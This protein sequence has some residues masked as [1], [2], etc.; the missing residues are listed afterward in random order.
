M[1]ITITRE[2]LL[3]PLGY[4]AGVVERRQTLPVLSYIL[5]RQKDLPIQYWIN[6]RF[7]RH[8]IFN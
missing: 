8:L 4:V 3:K 5:L 7:K 6:Q 2:D 1:Q